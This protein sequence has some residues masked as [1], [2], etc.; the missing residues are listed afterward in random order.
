MA[1][2]TCTGCSQEDNDLICSICEAQ[3]CMSCGK[4]NHHG[5]GRCCWEGDH[6]DCQRVM[7]TYSTFTEPCLLSACFP[8]VACLLEWAF[9]QWQE[10][11]AIS[12][13][14]LEKVAMVESLLTGSPHPY[15]WFQSRHSSL[16]ISRRMSRRHAVYLRGC[17]R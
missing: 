8:L 5:N 2:F 13:E 11:E 10:F 9:H 6:C 15:V 12:E 7:G 3:I 17:S 4:G 1:E 16:V 14:R